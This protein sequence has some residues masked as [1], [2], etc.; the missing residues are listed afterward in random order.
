MRL[1][2]I[3]VLG[4]LL[5]GCLAQQVAQVTTFD[6]ADVAAQLENGANTIRGS[7]LFNQ[8]GGG[9]VTCAGRDVYLVPK[10]KFADE[11]MQIIYGTLQGGLAATRNSP[12][13]DE[14]QVAAYLASS[15][16]TICDAQGFFKFENIADGQFYVQSTITWGEYGLQ[17]GALMRPVTV[18]GGETAELVLAP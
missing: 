10:S 16:K 17:G 4:F 7:A 2:S 3:F 5:A 18:T 12:T 9:T 13:A 15:K 1:I 6:K 14:N 11:R 8:V